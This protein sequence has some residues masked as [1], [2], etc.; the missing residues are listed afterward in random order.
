MYQAKLF[1]N[2]RTKQGRRVYGGSQH[3][4]YTVTVSE[5]EAYSGSKMVISS[6]TEMLSHVRLDH[7]IY[8]GW[9]VGDFVCNI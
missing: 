4:H 1:E 9:T 7:G 2:E 3:F 8:N 6:I 5:T